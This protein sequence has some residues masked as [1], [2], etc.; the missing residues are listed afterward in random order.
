MLDSAVDK[1]EDKLFAD[2]EPEQAP[3]MAPSH[4]VDAADTEA[5]ADVELT[6]EQIADLAEAIDTM[7]DSPLRHEKE[8]MAELE[9]ERVAAH[10]RVAEAKSASKQVAMLDSR[11]QLVR[12]Q[13]SNAVPRPYRLLGAPPCSSDLVVNPP[14]SSLLVNAL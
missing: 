4:A 13:R 9:A 3:V 6:R 11:V 2:D 7:I 12:C 14:C 5:D 8:E 1:L 10:D